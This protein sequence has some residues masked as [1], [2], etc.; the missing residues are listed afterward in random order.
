M[1]ASGTADFPFTR[2]YRNTIPYLYFIQQQVVWGMGLPLGLIALAGSGWALVKV[3]VAASQGGRVD[4]LG[5]GSSHTLASPALF[6]PSSTA[7]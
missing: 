7:I 3:L 5:V 2:Q 6:W 1:V 4:R